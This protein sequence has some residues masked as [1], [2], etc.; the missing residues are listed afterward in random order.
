MMKDEH[1]EHYREFL[2]HSLGKMKEEKVPPT[3][4]KDWLGFTLCTSLARQHQ[5]SD[6][7]LSSM[8]KKGMTKDP[9]FKE[10]IN[11]MLSLLD[12]HNVYQDYL[13]DHENA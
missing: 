8:I 5:I 9:Y 10:V 12:G 13:R 2:N 6:D 1:K 11:Y 3:E 7:E 4:I